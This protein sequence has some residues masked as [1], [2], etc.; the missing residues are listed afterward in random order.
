MRSIEDYYLLQTVP[1][2]GRVFGVQM[3]NIML[4]ACNYHCGPVFAFFECT[5]TPEYGTTVH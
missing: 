4:D 2:L 5:H 1:S 3:C